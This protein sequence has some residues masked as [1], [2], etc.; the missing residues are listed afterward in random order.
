MFD[1]KT[2]QNTHTHIYIYIHA[3]YVITYT[4]YFYTKVVLILLWAC[5]SLPTK[6]SPVGPRTHQVVQHNAEGQGANEL[7]SMVVE[8]W[9]N[10]I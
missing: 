9:F 4:I 2:I 8:W 5:R 1:G 10:G 6:K 3:L 7:G